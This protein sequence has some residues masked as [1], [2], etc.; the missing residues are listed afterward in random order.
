MLPWWPKEATLN[1]A[2]EETLTLAGSSRYRWRNHLVM[3]GGCIISL[4]VAASV[5]ISSET[6]PALNFGEKS[7]DAQARQHRIEPSDDRIGRLVL[8]LANKADRQAVLGER[9]LAQ[10]PDSGKRINLAKAH[11]QTLG[12]FV[13]PIVEAIDDGETQ[14]P[15]RPA[16]GECFRR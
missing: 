16:R 6:R 8:I 13:A 5:G 9:G 11:F 14:F 10:F 15:G 4:Q 7:G 2:S 1:L 3:G 12:L